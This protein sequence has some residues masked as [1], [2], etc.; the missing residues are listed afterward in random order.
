MSEN[1]KN[2]AGD[3]AKTEEKAAKKEKKPSPRK[4]K[5]FSAGKIIIIAIVVVALL[6]VLFPGLRSC[7]VNT[8]RKIPGVNK[9]IPQS[10]THTAGSGTYSYYTVT[11]RDITTSLAGTGTLQAY[12]SYNITAT[13]T[14][15]I[16]SA[17]FEEMDE[18]KEDDVLF[19]I[20]SADIEEDIEDKKKDVADA[21]EDINELY[22]DYEDLKIYSDYS[23]KIR[24][25]YVEA[26]DRVADGTAIAYVVDSDTMLLEVPFFAANTDHI[27]KGAKATVTFSSTGEVLLGTVSEI[28]NLTSVNAYNST[29]RNITVAVSNPGGIT[30]GMKAYASVVGND[31]I[32]YDCSG[33]GT[34]KYNEEET[35]RAESS[36]ELEAVYIDDGDYVK[37]GDLVA[38]ISSESLDDQLENLRKVYDNQQKALEDLEERLE[39]YTITA[40]IS[41]TVVQKNYKELDTIGSS[42][43]SSTTNLA[44]IYDM[45]KLTFDMNIDEL[46]LSL[47][48][49]GQKVNITSDS[50]DN[51]VFEGVITKKSIVGS[52]TGGTTV[53]PVT[54]EVEGNDHLL[55]GM[56]VDAEIILSST[57]EVPAVPVS[58]VGR[59]NIV[60]I[61]K[62]QV[63]RPVGTFDAKPET[64]TVN[65][66]IGA[67]DGDYIEIKSGLSV[68]DVVVYEVKN[69]QVQEFNM[70]N[71]MSGM[72]GMSGGN[73]GGMPQGGNFDRGGMGGGNRGGNTGGMPSGR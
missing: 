28:S 7:A 10:G 46:D 17:D 55:P 9:L 37:K 31:G 57:G 67:T 13:V 45:S 2:T 66:E 73:M 27:A 42:S 62:A 58:A 22:E 30:F 40:P 70:L 19:V 16:L 12:D 53:Y 15:D 69:V 59:G 35:I 38:Q 24:E 23:G 65:V 36:G 60:E 61:T 4:K 14:G 20:D 54:V 68:G 50:L 25:V 3:A 48:K 49:V 5:K 52:S 1:Q 6:L 56:N 39:D 18:V 29:I 71:M 64:E 44:I 63:E 8:A 26:G 34:F 11:A 21:L 72:G 43:M 41:G 47:I 33:E 51:M 32:T